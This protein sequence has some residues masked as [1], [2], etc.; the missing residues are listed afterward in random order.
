MP[1]L[2]TTS[3]LRTRSLRSGDRSRVWQ[4]IW[5]TKG[6]RARGPLHRTDGYD[7]LTSRQFEWL[8]RQI[9]QPLRIRSGQSVL[10]CGCGAGAFLAVLMKLHPNLRVAGIDYSR[11]LLA[12]AIR[13]I[14]GCFLYGDI[15]SIPFILSESFNHVVSFGTFIYLASPS[16]ATRALEEMIRATKPGGRLL[17]G[18]VSDA[19][20]RRLAEQL[21]AKTH[22]TRRTVAPGNPDHLYLHKS[23]FLRIAARH[24]LQVRIV[25]HSDLD[26]AYWATAPYRYS[27]YLKKPRSS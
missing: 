13:R 4:E 26:L 11:S 15:S 14:P 16:Q 2:N 10:E 23:F 12:L 18:E 1:H 20:K 8:V 24:G 19:A 6:H 27:V 25:D 21:R 9:V 17:I 22:A 3:T 7:L 5:A